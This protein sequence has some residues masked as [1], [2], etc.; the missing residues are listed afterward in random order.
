MSHL[1]KLDLLLAAI[2][3]H[4][5]LGIFVMNSST[6]IGGKFYRSLALPF[7]PDLLADQ[8]GAGVMAW[9]LGEIPILVVLVALL[10]QS[11]ADKSSH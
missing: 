1:G 9:T 6:V 8:R 10:A 4:T 7:V 11:R 5:F 3:F 2:P